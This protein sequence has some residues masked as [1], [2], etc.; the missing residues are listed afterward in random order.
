MKRLLIAACLIAV[1]ALIG[2]Q[3]FEQIASSAVSE[4]GR[5]GKPKVAVEVQAVTKT[6]ISDIGRFTGSLKPKSRFLVA[7]KV[8][9]RLNRMM[10]NIGDQLRQG[11]TIAWL[12][13][14]EFQQ[15]LHQAKAYLDVAR[16]NLEAAEGLLGSAERELERI[17][18]LRSK[19]L[20]SASELDQAQSNY[21]KQLSSYKVAKAQLSEKTAAFEVA[22]IRLSYTKIDNVWS[23]NGARLVVGERFV[24]EGTLLTGNTPIISIL[25]L[26]SMVGVIH[27]T[28]NDYFKVQRGQE[29]VVTVD[30]LNNRTFSGT[31]IRISPLVREETREAR[32]E[33]DIKNPSGILKP[34]L[35]IRVSIEFSHRDNVSVIPVSAVV[36]RDEATGVFV[37]DVEQEKASFVPVEI[38]IIQDDLAEVL[39]PELSGYVVTLGHHLL[40]D[41]SS[42]VI[43]GL[44]SEAGPTNV[45]P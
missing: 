26:S 10:V 4:G 25:D 30:A 35:F 28:E 21:T 45:N 23:T 11:Q 37:A 1:L 2:W 44:E 20:I 29:A 40:E 15:E 22:R 8:S 41:S 24:D 6:G 33:L 19:N 31:I 7:P 14:A 9:G 34:G 12:D 18:Q 32:V 38:G 27:V 3:V 39:S 16:A 5:R 42:I 36:K 17:Q 13:D 43:P